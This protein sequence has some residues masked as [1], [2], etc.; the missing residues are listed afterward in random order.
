MPKQFIINVAYKI[1]G[2]QFADWVKDRV[3]LRNTKV[4]QER[5]LLIELDPEIYAA[6]TNSTAVP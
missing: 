5:K 4:T 2:K 3:V 6:F 1:V